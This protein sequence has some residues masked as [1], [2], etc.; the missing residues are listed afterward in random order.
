MKTGRFIRLLAGGMAAH[1]L[2]VIFAI[3]SLVPAWSLSILAPSEPATLSA[4]APDGTI[5]LGDGRSLRLVDLEAP[6]SDAAVAAW[7]SAVAILQGQ[8]VT[9]KIQGPGID[10][11]GRVLA[12]VEKPDHLS[13]Q[14]ALVAGGY[15]RVMPTMPMG[16]A[17][18]GLLA[19]EDRARRARRGI[20]G[21]PA[22]A[23][24]KANQIARLEALAGR[25]ALVE[26]TIL[27]AV[28]RKDRLYFNF[29][30]DWRTDF[31]VTVAPADARLGVG[32]RADGK[33]VPL[34]EL[35]G[36]RVRVRGFIT[37]YN[38]PEM[39]VTSSDQL[40]FVGQGAM[41]SEE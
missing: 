15:A 2:A 35:I 30:P 18:S 31:T 19:D 24:I 40:E 39:I 5:T 17:T 33:P 32:W 16:F 20:W 41:A 21:D 37:R 14:S 8:T 7:R 23:I 27:D 11:Y 9:L 36:R 6:Q 38:G 22:F 4:I 34:P 29:G 28:S 13:L 3:C 1:L 26:G 10:R 12:V 25:Y